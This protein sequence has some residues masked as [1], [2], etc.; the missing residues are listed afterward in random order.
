MLRDM[1]TQWSKFLLMAA[2]LSLALCASACSSPTLRVVTSNEPQ[3][4][5][6]EAL[7]PGSLTADENGCI[8]ARTATDPVTLVWPQGYSVKGN[9]ES[10]EIL[11]ASNA[12]VA[13]SGVP[14]NIGGGSADS[15]L[16]SWSGRDCANGKLWMVGE[17]ADG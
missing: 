6:M 5:G 14:L 11:D 12:V 8:Y 7:L 2:T 4:S 17:I 10:F 16:D 9:S 1:H 15:F 3:S 13:R